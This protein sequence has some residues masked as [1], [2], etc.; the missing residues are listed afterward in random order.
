[1]RTATLGPVSGPGPGLTIGAPN[2]L[3]RNFYVMRTAT[4]G[5][6]SGPGPGLTIGCAHVQ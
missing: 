2:C 4:L 1:M 6:V 5:P 3:K